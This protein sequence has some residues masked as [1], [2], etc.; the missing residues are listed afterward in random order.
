MGRVDRDVEQMVL[1][2]GRVGGEGQWGL[3]GRLDD[4]ALHDLPATVR[5]GDR[6]HDVVGGRPDEPHEID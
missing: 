1:E 2:E 3:H 4:S 5:R 6:G